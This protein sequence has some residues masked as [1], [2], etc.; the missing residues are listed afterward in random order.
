MKTPSEYNKI[1][2]TPVFPLLV[3]LHGDVN[4]YSDKNVLEEISTMDSNLVDRIVPILK[5][6]PLVVVGYRGWETSIMQHLFLNKIDEAEGF[7][8]GIYWCVRKG[9]GLEQSTDYVKS[10]VSRIGTNFSFV[11]IEGFD[12]LFDKVIWHI[13]VKKK[14]K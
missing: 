10:L 11:E 6:H 2:S 9:Q 13:W 12:H 3:Y 7:K 5:D 8:N 14:P 1:S 4:N